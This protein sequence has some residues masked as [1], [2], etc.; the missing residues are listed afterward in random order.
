M[1][2]DP[3]S[4]IAVEMQCLARDRVTAEV[5][6]ALRADG[7]RSI[8]LKGASY[9]AWL[10]ADGTPRAYRDTD[11][12][13]APADVAAAEDVLGRL[14]FAHDPLD[15][16]AFD[17]PWHGHEWIRA[18][19]GAA[20]DLHRTLIGVSVRPEMTWTVLGRSTEPLAVGGTTVEVLDAPRR[21]LHVA[22]H[23][24]QD[25]RR[26]RTSAQD[27][28]RAVALLGLEVWRAAADVAA[29]LG[30]DAAM[31]AGL[32]LADGGAA[33]AA[34]LG[35]PEQV[36]SGVR[37]RA[38]G[39][40]PEAV[41]LDWF[42]GLGPGG[43]IRWAVSKAFPPPAFLRAWTPVARRG[44]LGLAVAYPLRLGWLVRRLPRAVAARASRR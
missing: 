38:E 28:D 14:G 20:V 42:A 22:L 44:R 41:A 23:A 1:T 13:V 39:A 37:L 30:A 16:L 34:A 11:L 29:E 31:A 3:A 10:Y 8:L 35:L 26:K 24:A 9:K 12:L 4:A 5:V 17:K 40:P 2:G 15:D 36:P 19:D 6:G 27:L 7:I 25:G 21:A 33:I 32:R 43:K 18:S